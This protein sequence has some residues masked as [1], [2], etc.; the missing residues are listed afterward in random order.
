V[1]RDEVVRQ[2][3]AA[4]RRLDA[5]PEAVLPMLCAATGCSAVQRLTISGDCFRQKTSSGCWHV[6][7][8]LCE[9]VDCRL[10]LAVLPGNVLGIE[11]PIILRGNLIVA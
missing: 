7:K 3:A 4:F 1:L 8:L 6:G 9:S 2:L 5:D 11:F 10:F